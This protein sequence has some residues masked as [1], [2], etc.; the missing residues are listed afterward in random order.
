MGSFSE[1]ALADVY[2]YALR[3]QRQR[4]MGNVNTGQ[5]GWGPSCWRMLSSLVSVSLFTIVY[6]CT[7]PF[8]P[9]SVVVRPLARALILYFDSTDGREMGIEERA[10]Q[11]NRYLRWLALWQSTESLWI[12]FFLFSISSYLAIFLFFLT[13]SIHFFVVD[14]KRVS[15]GGLT[16]QRSNCRTV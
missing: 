10:E 8:C 4:P 13:E 7:N 14:D 11:Q 6:M 2:Q 3:C 1:S 15:E 5:T 16:S 9:H 12:T